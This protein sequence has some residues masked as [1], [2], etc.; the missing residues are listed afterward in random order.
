MK[1][2]ESLSIANRADTF[3]NEDLRR[4]TFIELRH[5][6]QSADRSFSKADQEQFHKAALKDYKI[7]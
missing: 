4:N 7:S 3:I 5:Q 1:Y 2:K 6:N